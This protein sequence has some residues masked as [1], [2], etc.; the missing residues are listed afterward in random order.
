MGLEEESLQSISSHISLNDERNKKLQKNG[1]NYSLSP[2]P[3]LDMTLQCER[4]ADN[5]TNYWPK[6]RNSKNK[7]L[8]PPESKSLNKDTFKSKRK[9]EHEEK[10][11]KN[12]ETNYSKAS[13]EKLEIDKDQDMEDF[14]K[15]TKLKIEAYFSNLEV[16]KYQEAS[17]VDSNSH[18]ETKEGL[19]K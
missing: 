17:F 3:D 8:R 13:K 9:V 2:I 14:S 16:K 11:K 7:Q 1:K 15:F 10:R 19:P 12:N 18:E 4:K 5:W 6:S